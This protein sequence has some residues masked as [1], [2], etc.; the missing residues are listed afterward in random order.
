MYSWAEETCKPKLIKAEITSDGMFPFRNKLANNLLFYTS[1]PDQ[2]IASTNL[3]VLKFNQTNKSIKISEINKKIDNFESN[4]LFLG[5]LGYNTDESIE[6]NTLITNRSAWNI[7]CKHTLYEI[8]T[9]NKAYTIVVADENSENKKY[10]AFIIA[11]KKS[12]VFILQF[13]NFS[14]LEVKQI[15]STISDK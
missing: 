13:N 11:H 7:N 12:P 10:N 15:L 9:L 1:I 14:E 8:K 6:K 2:L 3:T 5:L 4:T